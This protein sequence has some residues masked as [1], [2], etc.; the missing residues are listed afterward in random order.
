MRRHIYRRDGSPVR[1]KIKK[2]TGGFV[3]WYRV[4][5]DGQDGWQPAKPDDYVAV[6]Y[7]G[8]CRSIFC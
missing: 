4:L 5:R 8:D 3:N 6:P 1:I 2:K 7:I